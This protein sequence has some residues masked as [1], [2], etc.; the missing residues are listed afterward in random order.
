MRLQCGVYS[1]IP[2]YAKQLLFTRQDTSTGV[3]L[4]PPEDIKPV[5]S[6]AVFTPCQ[7]NQLAC[8]LFALQWPQ[9]C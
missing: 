1:I 6:W 3:G 8:H 7:V 2:F 9:K 4:L 5:K